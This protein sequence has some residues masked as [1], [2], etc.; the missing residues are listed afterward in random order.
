MERPFYFDGGSV[1]MVFKVELKYEFHPMIA[2]VNQQNQRKFQDLGNMKMGQRFK[3]EQRQGPGARVS[4]LKPASVPVARAPVWGR[5]S[6]GIPGGTHK[7]PAASPSHT[8]KVLVMLL[9]EPYAQQNK[10]ETKKSVHIK[11]DSSPFQHI[12]KAQQGVLNYN[13]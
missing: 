10:A 7:L 5:A 4:F 6:L 13:S 11:Y 1:Y 12:V 8:T 9:Q 2:D 3:E